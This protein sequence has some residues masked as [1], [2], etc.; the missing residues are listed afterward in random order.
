LVTVYGMNP[1]VG[2]SLGGH[3]FSFY[4]LSPYLLLRVF[5]S[6]SKN[7]LSSHTL[8]FLLIEIHVVCELYPGYLELWANIHLSVSAFHMFSF[9]IGLPHSG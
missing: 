7:D 6:P 5:C 8:V 3:S 2:Q 1:H 9:A 4:T